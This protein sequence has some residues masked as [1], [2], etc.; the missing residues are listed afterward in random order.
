MGVGPI[1]PG[2]AHL[3]DTVDAH[4]ASAI[5]YAGSTN[6]SANNV[7]SALDELANEQL[8]AFNVVTYGADP[9]GTSDSTSAILAADAACQTAGGGVVWFPAGTYRCDSQLTLSTDGGTPVPKAKARVWMGAGAWMSGKSTN[10]A[11]NG[12]SILDLRY[13][14]GPGLFLEPEGRLGL[15]GLTFTQLGTAHTQPMILVT[16]TTAHIDD[17]AFYGHSTK[18][19]TSCDQDAIVIGDT[20]TSI[21]TGTTAPFQGYGTRIRGCHFNRIKRGVWG[22]M[23]ANAVKVQD[24]TWWAQCGGSAAIE[25]DGGGDSTNYN[26]GA[27][28]VGN[29]IE[30]VGYT[31]A[32]T[33]DY[34]LNFTLIGNDFYDDSAIAA[35]GYISVGAHFQYSTIIAGHYVSSKPY[36]SSA[37]ANLVLDPAQSQTSTFTQPVAFTNTTGVDITQLLVSKAQVVQPAASA[38]DGTE[39]LHLKRSAA[40]A[41]NP[42]TTVFKV[43]QNGAITAGGAQGGNMT[44]LDASGAAVFYVTNAGKVWTAAGSGG[45]MKINS[46]TGGSYMDMQHYGVRYYDHTGTLQRTDGAGGANINA[47]SGQTLD[48][49]TNGTS[50]IAMNATGIGFFAATPAAKPTVTGSCGGNAALA[51]LITA[52]A[53]LGL[54]T[55]SS[56]A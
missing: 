10:S 42:G 43:Q 41:S 54:V 1:T 13:S 49:K 46:G 32:M 20:T 6:L 53:T 22:R 39:L 34:C 31:R 27:T 26:V 25:F 48:L 12:G 2:V 14:S 4:D 15:T 28:I 5:S 51:S 11:P 19:T 30:C 56:T 50:R 29:L 52:L 3:A 7:E 55:D 40:E 33:F 18:T 17:C 8:A 45:N 16:N 24:N 44:F 47:A 21:G 37:A 23:Y 35:G 36:V 38:A 9:T